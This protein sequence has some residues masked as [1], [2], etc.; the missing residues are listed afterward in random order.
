MAIFYILTFSWA[1]VSRLWGLSDFV[2]QGKTILGTRVIH[3]I[4]VWF[5]MSAQ[6]CLLTWFPT[7]LY[8]D[9]AGSGIH[10]PRF[11]GWLVR[12]FLSYKNSETGF[13]Q[14]IL[15]AIWRIFVPSGKRKIKKV[16]QEFYF[17]DLRAGWTK[18]AGDVTV[19]IF[20]KKLT[21]L[22]TRSIPMDKFAVSRSGEATS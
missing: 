2:A 6:M 1:G 22:F 12:E 16:I 11:G 13:R 20:E 4:L 21:K 14:L 9:I 5:R 15:F 3:Y 17:S 7:P 10:P 18:R 8:R 19:E